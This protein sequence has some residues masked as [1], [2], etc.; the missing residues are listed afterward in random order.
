MYKNTVKH[1]G[2]AKTQGPEQQTILYK[3]GTG[4]AQ[5]HLNKPQCFLLFI[6]KP[7]DMV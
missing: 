5:D 3:I 1:M 2:Q 6:G 4:Q 7:A